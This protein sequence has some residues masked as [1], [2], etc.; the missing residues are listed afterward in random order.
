MC[1]ADDDFVAL[2]TEYVEQ[3]LERLREMAS[4]EAKLLFAESSRDPTTPLPAISE[5]ISFAILRV[6][7]ALST[8]MDSYAE[9]KTLWC[10]V[11]CPA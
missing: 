2:K 11:P 6:A 3:V 4:L 9:D 5:R 8:L 7:D 10:G 1:V